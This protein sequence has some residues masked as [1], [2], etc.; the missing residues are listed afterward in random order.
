VKRLNGRLSLHFGQGDG[1][2]PQEEKTK[3]SQH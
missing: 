1:S 2:R 3:H